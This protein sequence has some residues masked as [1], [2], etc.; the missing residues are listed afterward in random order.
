VDALHIVSHGSD[1]NVRLGD[2]TVN[3]KNLAPYAGQIGQWRSSLSSDADLLFYG[4]DLAASDYGQQ[5]VHAFGVLT[6]ADVAA[7]D[8]LTGHASLGGD[9]E[10]EF[11]VGVID[12][13]IAFSES[14]QSDWVH[15]LPANVAPV[16]TVPNGQLTYDDTSVEFSASNGNAITV[17]DSDARGGRALMS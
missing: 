16:N 13:S 1:G 17:S 10:L 4:C 3:I 7:S 6:G 14:I 2:S 12:V 8:G 15:I 9:W 11:G 5:L